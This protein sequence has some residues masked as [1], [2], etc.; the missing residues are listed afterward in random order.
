MVVVLRENI[1]TKD[2]VLN[3]MNAYGHITE[4]EA[5]EFLQM[6]SGLSDIIKELKYDGIKIKRIKK[7]VNGKKFTSYE[8]Q[9]EE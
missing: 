9:K 4:N 7:E 6:E 5:K 1:M 3:F 8:L 2:S